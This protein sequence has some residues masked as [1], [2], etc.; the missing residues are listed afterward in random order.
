MANALVKFALET[1]LILFALTD[2]KPNNIKRNLFVLDYIKI[3]HNMQPV[4]KTSSQPRSPTEAAGTHSVPA[5]KCGWLYKRGIYKKSNLIL[6]DK[7]LFI[8]VNI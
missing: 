7:C 1:L 6:I 2:Q 3:N 4:T 5:Y 8:K